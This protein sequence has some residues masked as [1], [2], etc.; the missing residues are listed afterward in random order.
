MTLKKCMK[1]N[2]PCRQVIGGYFTDSDFTGDIHK[3]TNGLAEAAAML[4]WNLP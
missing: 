4:G 1:L 2:R 3:F